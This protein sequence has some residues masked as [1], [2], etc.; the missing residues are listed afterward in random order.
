MLTANP[1]QG[2]EILSRNREV[3]GLVNLG[4]IEK[5]PPT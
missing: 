5:L 2:T 3:A 1:Q 4:D